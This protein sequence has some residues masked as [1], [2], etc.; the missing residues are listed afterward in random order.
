M[1]T[2]TRFFLVGLSLLFVLSAVGCSN[3][4]VCEPGRVATC[5]CPSGADGTQKCEIDGASWAGCQCGGLDTGIADALDTAEMR[6]RDTSELLEDTR[7][8]DVQ[9]TDTKEEDSRDVCTPDCSGRDCGPDPVCGEDCGECSGV[10][11][12]S[13]AGVCDQ[14]MTYTRWK[15]D[16][17]VV[18]EAIRFNAS[19]YASR[20]LTVLV[21]GDGARR[22][23][24]VGGYSSVNLT[25][26]DV[27][28]IDAFT[29]TC[30]SSTEVN[31]RAWVSI[32][33]SFSQYTYSD[34]LPDI[35]K[36]L[37]FY[38]Y[39]CGLSLS[40]PD[41]IVSRELVVEEVTKSRVM[42]SFSV[43]IQG[44]GPREGSTLVVEGQFD[45]Q[46]SER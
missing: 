25:F 24:N 11:T 17:Q 7:E 33:T 29:S 30:A 8:H 44:G 21:I 43:E 27:S 32:S 4:Q 38:T 40:D 3:S 10:N 36:D 22:S 6:E 28:T 13:A 1:F 2:V 31:R 15:L 23:G 39:D 9:G 41:D 5:P 14:A 19:H 16:G 45:A 12:C 26:N 35:W 18:Y 37:N 34:T 46:T 20:D 42:G